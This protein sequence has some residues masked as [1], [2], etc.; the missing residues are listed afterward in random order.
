MSPKT[1]SSCARTNS[2][3]SVWT[4]VTATVLCAVSATSADIPWQP[5]AANAFRSA[6]IPAPPPES[7]VAI[8]R[9]R[10]T[11]QLPSPVRTG[12]GSTGVISARTGTLVTR[13][14][15]RRMAVGAALWDDLLEGE[16]V[17][18]VA[19][20]PSA[21]ARTAPLPEELHPKLRA[22]LT[23]RGLTELYLH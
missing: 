1:A 14:Y 5:A 17:A 19:E 2:G 23:R 12:S 15:H 20:I 21:E 11:N 3:G 10:G 16:E 4:S 7:D 13:G 22:A 6:W 18:H 8:V 9:Q